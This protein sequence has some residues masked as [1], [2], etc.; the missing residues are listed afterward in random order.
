MPQRDQ[1]ER[2]VN[3]EQQSAARHRHFLSVVMIASA[4][5]NA[6]VRRIL[7]G[8]LRASDEVFVLEEGTAIVM[9]QTDL[10]GARKSVLRFID[11]GEE[12]H[13]LRFSI[14]TYPSDSGGRCLILEAEE[15]LVAAKQ[16]QFGEVVWQN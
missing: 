4:D 12:M 2:K 7:R 5:S 14:A 15:R 11:H 1:L 8:S 10:E 16:G 3:V 13:D 9:A 6:A